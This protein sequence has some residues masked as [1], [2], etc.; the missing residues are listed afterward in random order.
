MSSSLSGH[1]DDGMDRA[2]NL[3]ISTS[4]SGQQEIP[5][6]IVPSSSSSSLSLN[7]IT[8]TTKNI[9]SSHSPVTPTSNNNTL[10]SNHTRHRRLPSSFLLPSTT[11][12]TTTTPTTPTTSTPSSTTSHHTSPF[13]HHHHSTTSTSSISNNKH[14]KNT[15]TNTLGS[16]RV[17][18]PPQQEQPSSLTPTRTP[19]P[20]NINTLPP[21]NALFNSTE[22]SSSSE[23]EEPFRRIQSS[24]PPLH[25]LSS[26]AP[27]N[28]MLGS[29]GEP[30]T[31]TTITTT[32]TNHHTTSTTMNITA[33]NNGQG[34]SSSHPNSRHSYSNSNSAAAAST[35]FSN[36]VEYYHP[37]MAMFIKRKFDEDEEYLIYSYPNEIT[38]PNIHIRSL[39]ELRGTLHSVFGE[40]NDILNEEVRFC[41]LTPTGRSVSGH[42]NGGNG[43]YAN[44]PAFT[45]AGMDSNSSALIHGSSGA[46][47]GHT[48]S[49]LLG[50]STLP[51]S[52]SPLSGLLSGSSPHHH[53]HSSS[54]SSVPPQ[55]QQPQSLPPP[56]S[57]SS[58]PSSSGGGGGGGGL[59][60]S[61][62]MAASS[63]PNETN[64]L[65]QP[66]PP[67]ASLLEFL[68][69]SR[70]N[71]S[72]VSSPPIGENTNSNIIYLRETI[73]KN[74]RPLIVTYKVLKQYI[75]LLY[76]PIPSDYSY[77]NVMK[78]VYEQYVN[79]LFEFLDFIYQDVE[80]IISN[81]SDYQSQL[82]TIFNRFFEMVF[83]DRDFSFVN[84]FQDGF[85]KFQPSFHIT[86][87][88]DAELSNLETIMKEDCFNI[89]TCL[90]YKG[91]LQLSHLPKNITK[92]V[93]RYLTH[94]NIIHRA[95]DSPEM[96]IIEKVFI[97]EQVNPFGLLS[98]N[99]SVSTHDNGYDYLLSV[100]TQGEKL[101]CSV[102]YAKRYPQS[103][104]EGD[105]YYVDEMR[106][107]LLQL[108]KKGIFSQIRS[109]F[110]TSHSLANVLSIPT[111]S[112]TNN[113]DSQRE[114]GGGGSMNDSS[115][116]GSSG[117]SGSVSSNNSGAHS[118]DP[119]NYANYNMKHFVTQGPYNVLLGYVVHSNSNGLILFH[120]SHN[121]S[122]ASVFSLKCQVI[123]QVL[124][125]KRMIANGSQDF[126]QIVEFGI[127]IDH[128]VPLV[129]T[130]VAQ[131]GYWICGRMNDKLDEFYVC[132]EDSIPQEVVELSYRLYSRLYI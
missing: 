97:K 75:F 17:N 46:G 111:V 28:M 95:Q 87:T 96:V 12:T 4:P 18:T 44:S 112:I 127:H 59:L 125:S 25:L 73:E 129:G 120:N 56:P 118:Y 84:S 116:G 76:L 10:G 85:V 22:P 106:T 29:V 58:V 72:L 105:L 86:Q 93:I 132:Y 5:K 51:A 9:P 7:I 122:I 107:C 50:A 64:L 121:S 89:G 47:G 79:E 38:S 23:Q 30:T 94:F 128:R 6:L 71:P 33:T 68:Q 82:D 20:P 124:H 8:N 34:S 66:S 53:P 98:V 11:T 61:H 81:I 13:D 113:S 45:W 54:H 126:D 109:Q 103:Y 80:E 83:H 42:S 49:P 131:V 36:N 14:N 123:R 41:Y 55:P 104:Y 117:S 48:S 102:L 24:L 31:A 43:I 57:S 69:E 91:L 65:E 78:L 92:Q 63:Q 119:S 100:I 35:S 108:E 88:I 52:T 90:I 19:P 115:S 74:K 77:G 114:G 101:M 3:T 67:K 2:M 62:L 99:D 130:S 27:S 32:T 39:K 16:S 15:N 1:D 60:E 26:S 40:C 110:K 21:F 37:H 70:M